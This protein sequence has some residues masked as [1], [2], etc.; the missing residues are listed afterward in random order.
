VTE[1]VPLIHER[2]KI[3]DRSQLAEMLSYF[4][5]DEIWLDTAE[6]MQKGMTEISTASALESAA[7]ALESAEP[8]EAESLEQ[9]FRA[10]CEEL[11]LKPRQLFG[12]LRVSLTARR[13]APPL[14]DTIVAIG[15]DKSIN[16]IRRAA[17]LLSDSSARTS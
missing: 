2:L 17:A 5:E 7:A 10:L 8:F 6:V 13:I 16:R 4:F 3:I 14:F 9:R 1:L 12:A 15:R 11:E